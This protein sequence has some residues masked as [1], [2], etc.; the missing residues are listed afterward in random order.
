MSSQRTV[1][2]YRRVFQDVLET[3]GRNDVA[4]E[5][6]SVAGEGILSAAFVR[7]LRTRRIALP[8]E[9]LVDRTRVRSAIEGALADLTPRGADAPALPPAAPEMRSRTQTGSIGGERSSTER[10]G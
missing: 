10:R 6:V 2:V 5:E 7:G 1:P 3:M 8:L 4:V 9:Q